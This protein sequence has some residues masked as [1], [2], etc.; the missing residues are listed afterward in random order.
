[1]ATNQ[2]N[3]NTGSFNFGTMNVP[4]LGDGTNLT[5][6]INGGVGRTNVTPLNLFPEITGHVGETSTP[7]ATVGYFS[8]ITLVVAFKRIFQLTTAQERVNVQ[9]G[10]N[11][12]QPTHNSMRSREP[13]APDSGRDREERPQEEDPERLSSI[14]H[15]KCGATTTLQRV[16]EVFEP[17]IKKIE[18]GH[19]D[20]C[21]L[22]RRMK[23]PVEKPCFLEKTKGVS[24]RCSD[25]P[26][27]S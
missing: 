16:E 1:M 20:R 2:T 7:T 26:K 3:K 4:L 6:T 15:L 9:E 14:N 18:C 25:G 8:P 27:T 21:Y 10:L 19:N 17:R 11:L 12:N 22:K 24:K 5:N 13:V 23:I